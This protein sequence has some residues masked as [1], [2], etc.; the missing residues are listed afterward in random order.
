VGAGEEIEIPIVEGE[1]D[2][3]LG[4]SLRASRSVAS[5]SGRTMHR[6][7]SISSRR[8]A[9]DVELRVPPML[10]VKRDPVVAEDEEPLP[11][12]TRCRP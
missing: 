10:V 3:A 11:A 9:R 5:P 6:F 8:R 12:P 1:D 7:F 2:G 4:N